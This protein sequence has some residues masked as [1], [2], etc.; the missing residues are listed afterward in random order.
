MDIIVLVKEVLDPDLPPSKFSV[1]T[2]NNRVIPPEGIPSVISPYDAVA[3]EAALRIKEELGGRITVVSLGELSADVVVRKTLAMGADAGIVLC[4]PSFDVMDS[5]KTA[6]VLAQAI[7]KI[8]TYDLILCG[9]QAVDWD[10]GITGPVLA[11]YLGLPVVTLARAINVFDKKVRVERVIANGCEI[12]ETGLPA[13]IT[14]SNELGLPRIP[15]GWG[16]I[17]AVREEIPV[18]SA[19]DIEEENHTGKPL[20][21]GRL[22]KLYAPSYERKCEF[23]TGQEP[24][25]VAAALVARLY[26]RERASN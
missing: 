18:W 22:L 26:G 2:K 25:E 21:E 16:V 6:C 3:V 20:A 13:V 23:L 4:D 5:F 11:E 24:G 1:D 17:K 12:L 15:S 8:G 14:V 19:K 9:R 10:R 7:R